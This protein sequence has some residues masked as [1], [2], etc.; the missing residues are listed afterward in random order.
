MT[1]AAH[2]TP[3][4]RRGLATIA[5]ISG[6]VLCIVG[7]IAEPRRMAAAYL[8]AYVA[9]LA[10][11][12]GVLA[13]IMIA[14]LTAATW[15]VAL[16]RQAEQVTATLPVLAVLFIPVLVASRWL[17]PWASPTGDPRL[18]AAMQAKSP[19]LNLPF[20]IARAILYW[21]VWLGLE[22]ILRRASLA[23]D[24]G[25][26]PSIAHRLRLASA[27]GIVAFGLTITFA[28]F[29]WMMSLAPT[30]YST[31]Y[32]VNYFAGA[33]VGGLALLAVLTERGRRRGELPET[34]G[35]DHLH[36]LAK[37]LLTFVLFWVY[38]GFSQFIVIW[39]AEIPVESSWY[40]VRTRGGWSALGMV[41]LIGHFVIPFLA[42][43]VLAVKRRPVLVA[44]L[45]IWLLVMHYL[46]CYWNVMPDAA[47]R[48]TWTPLAPL[49]D[50]AALLLIC[51]IASLAWSTRRSGEPAVP[52]GD[53]D[54]VP[55]LDYST[56]EVLG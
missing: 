36:A 6:A 28:A 20:F 32:G 55:S 9:V 8:V 13:M 11:V 22:E 54:L 53:P 2:T 44:A 37:L 40:V 48:T 17:Y 38:I 15:F 14:R 4:D 50:L 27:L 51:G 16:R 19:Y 46:D 12:L 35:A 43:L 21:A 23:Q 29:D 39:S 1:D 5:S 33:M 30:W 47:A 45:G 34:I 52:R 7:F 26:S 42:L 3:N 49:W 18:A 25:D 56:R 41:I 31:V 24:H 10:V